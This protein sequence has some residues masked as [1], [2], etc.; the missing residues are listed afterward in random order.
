[1]KRIQ[2]IAW[3]ALL[4][5]ATGCTQNNG[6]IGELYGFWRVTEK[7][8]PAEDQI[9]WAFQNDILEITVNLPHHEAIKSYGTYTCT[10]K[11]LRI[12]FTHWQVAGDNAYLYTIPKELG[13]PG[14]APFIMQIVERGGGSMTLE[15]EGR[16]FNL[17]K[18][19]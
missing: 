14:D 13:L 9:I 4:F 5:I 7:D 15:Y 8:A 3:L 17:K 16:I 2:Y 10:D 11:D 12:D 18:V 6:D 1:M 19:Y